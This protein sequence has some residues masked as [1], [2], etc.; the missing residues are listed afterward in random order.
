MPYYSP[1]R[2]KTLIS[3]HLSVSNQIGNIILA[4]LPYDVAEIFANCPLCYES[5]EG[6]I[7]IL[8]TAGNRLVPGAML[9][10]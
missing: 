9:G 7:R 3:L 1:V 10:I 4:T 5:L 6:D 8:C 2:E